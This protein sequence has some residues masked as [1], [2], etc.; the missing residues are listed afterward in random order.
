M[1]VGFTGT[2]EGMNERQLDQLALMLMALHTGRADAA[3]DFHFGGQFGAD[4]EARKIAKPLGFGIDWHPCPGVAMDT[5]V[6]KHGYDL[7]ELL[8]ERWHGC[9]PPLVRNHH[10]VDAA[11]VLVAA[12]RTDAEELRSGTWATIR[13]A[14]LKGL[15]VVMLTRGGR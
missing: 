2:R 13:Y 15:P 7:D 11:T 5:L 12:P 1:I 10:I 14:R 8:A 4:L 6:D 3:N 9:F